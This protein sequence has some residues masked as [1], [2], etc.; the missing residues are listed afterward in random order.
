MTATGRPRSA[1]TAPQVPAPF[2]GSVRPRIGGWTR[3]IAA[4]SCEVVAERAR[5]PGQVEQHRRARVLDLVHR[6]P[7]PGHEAPVAPA[8]DDVGGEGVPAGVVG[9]PARPPSPARPPA[10]NRAVLGD[11]E[12]PR[13]AAEQPGGE[14]ALQRLG[15]AGVGQPGGDRRGREPVVGERH[16]HRLEHRQLPGVGRRLAISQKASSPKPDL[17]DQL[18]GRGRGRGA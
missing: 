13:A 6:V 2:S 8:C 18:A 3:P 10:R 14:R 9:R 5:A 17:A 15:R 12:E 11:A 7:E 1:S 4:N 16:E